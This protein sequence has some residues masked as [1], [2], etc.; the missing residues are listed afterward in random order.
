MREAPYPPLADLA[1]I[2]DCKTAALVARDGSIEWACV[3]RF[4]GDAVFARLLDDARGGSWLLAPVEPYASTFAYVGRS[5]VLE[6]EHRTAGG[7]VRVR[8]VLVP[9]LDGDPPG[10]LVRVAEGLAGSVELASVLDPRPRFGLVDAVFE[11]L[12]DD[13]LLISGSDSELRLVSTIGQRG[14]EKRFVLEP[15]ERAGFLLGWGE[16]PPR[17]EA[18]F[19][20]VEETLA[21]WEAWAGGVAYSGPFAAAVARS[22]ITLKLCT[23]MTTGGIVAAPTSSLPELI[24]GEKN[25]DYRYTW[26]R[27]AALALYAFLATGLQ[28]EGDGFFDWICARVGE[29]RLDEGE[30]LRIMYD[31]DGGSDHHEETLPHLEGYRRSSPVRI[32]NAACTQTQLDVYGDV[33]DCFSTSFVW[34]RSDKLELWED[35]RPLADWICIHWEEADSGIW[36]LR[37]DDRHYV[38]SKV[39]AWVALDRAIRTAESKGLPGNLERWRINAALIHASVLEHGWSDELGGFKQAYD[40]ACLDASALLVPLVGFLPSDDARVVSNLE[41]TLDELGTDGLMYRFGGGVP[42]EGEG[43]GA[44]ALCSFWL[45]NAL[46][47]AGR[48]DEAAEVFERVLARRS[49]LGLLSEEIDPGSGELLGNYPQA[50]VHAGLLSAA[51]NLARAGG[52]GEAPASNHAPAGTA[53]LVA[54]RQGS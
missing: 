22:A 34:G 35:Y 52:I 15:G 10:L 46:A 28:T 9:P 14:R 41:R 18:A 49:P 6:T 13:A 45:V 17:A 21:W 31:V 30:G 1:L 29:T 24:G 54:T 23:H 5:A 7:A 33:L 50:F 27:D 39:M 36:E 42:G 53:H 3:P 2:G 38:Y 8:D 43:E 20:L 16:D 32:G 40:V 48:V 44:F 19:G 25:W 51:V 12:G 11:P 26:L 4:D 37:G 47:A